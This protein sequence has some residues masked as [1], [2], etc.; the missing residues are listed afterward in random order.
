MKREI[1]VQD[2]ASTFLTFESMSHKK[3]QKL[4]YY[5]QAWHLALYKRAL[6]ADRFQAWIHGPVCRDL[7]DEYKIHGWNDIPKI[8]N[9]PKNIGS[10]TYEFI[11]MVFNTYGEFSGDELEALTHAEEPW[12]EQRYDLEEWEPS[13]RI[14]SE[15]TMQDY[16]W[17]VYEQSQND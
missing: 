7:Y 5:A 11:D 6:F 10:D 14:I 17:K 9:R 13:N 3:L 4:C 8:K 15:K 2:I 1:T 16:Y 12:K